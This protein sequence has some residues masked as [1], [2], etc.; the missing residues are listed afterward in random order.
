MTADKL[1]KHNIMEYNLSAKKKSI[2]AK[3][4]R[5]LSK[6]VAAN[7][8]VTINEDLHMVLVH[9]GESTILTPNGANEAYN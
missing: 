4:Q 3:E 1:M 2:V 7:S 9:N 6:L 8:S 5:N